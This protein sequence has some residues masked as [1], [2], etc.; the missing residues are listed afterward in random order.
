MGFSS[1][2]IWKEIFDKIEKIPSFIEDNN[3]QL[4]CKKREVLAMKKELDEIEERKKHLQQNMKESLLEINQLKKLKPFDKYKF[5]FYDPIRDHVQSRMEI[6]NEIVINIENQFKNEIE[7]FTSLNDH[8]NPSKPKLTL[9]LN[10]CGISNETL[11]KLN[12]NLDGLE[13]IGCNI[14]DL[15]SSCDIN[16]FQ[17]KK[18]LEYIQ[19]MFMDHVLPDKNHDSVCSVCS[20]KNSRDLIKLLKRKKKKF[21]HQILKKNHI[22]GRRFLCI[23]LN[24]LRNEFGITDRDIVK[25]YFAAINSLRKLHKSAISDI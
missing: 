18:D 14:N 20:A 13:F 8:K 17:I 4:N 10:A 21:D 6:E 9:I 23:T 11:K 12:G 2:L 7:D 3:K 22:N 5:E 19:S 15:C 1:S 24:D 25:D 16:Q